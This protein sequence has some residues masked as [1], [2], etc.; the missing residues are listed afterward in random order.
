[1][2]TQ[3]ERL[4]AEILAEADSQATKILNRAKS[5]LLGLQEQA[6]VKQQKR[7]ETRLAET[8]KEAQARGG[9]LINTVDQ[10]I[11][12]R[13][14]TGREQVIADLFAQALKEAEQ[15]QGEA[16]AE[17]LR[18]LATEAIAA[19]GVGAYQVSCAPADT[20]VVTATWLADLSKTLEIPGQFAWQVTPDESIAGGLRFAALDGSRNFDNTYAARLRNLNST[21]RALLA[22][23]A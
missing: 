19:L 21:L 22:P 17:S 10:E 9:I 6:E 18:T 4:R 8:R 13:L 20:A 5:S 23:D 7:R 11:Q 3:E 14:L 15:S 16:R 2:D 1:M 12:R